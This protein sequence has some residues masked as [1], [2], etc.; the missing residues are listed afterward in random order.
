RRGESLLRFLVEVRRVGTLERLPTRER[1]RVVD[2]VEEVGIGSSI[3]GREPA[4]EQHL[5]HGVRPATTGPEL[6]PIRKVNGPRWA[7]SSISKARAA[8]AMAW[9]SRSTGTPDATM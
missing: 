8:A 6:I 9:S 7:E 1:H 4:H 3:R 2:D 5:A